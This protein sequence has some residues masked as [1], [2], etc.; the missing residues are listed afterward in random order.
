MKKVRV[1]RDRLEVRMGP[2]SEYPTN[3]EVWK[4]VEFYIIEEKNGFGRLKSKAGWVDMKG[5]EKA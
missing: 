1:K 3:G 4:G 5:C 2:S